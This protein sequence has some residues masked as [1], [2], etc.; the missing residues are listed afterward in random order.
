MPGRPPPEPR[1][2]TWDGERWAR[3]DDDAPRAAGAADLSGPDPVPWRWDGERW[4]PA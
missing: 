2:W 3:H 1:A 4:R